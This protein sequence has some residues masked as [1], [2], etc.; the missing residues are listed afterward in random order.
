MPTLTLTPTECQILDACLHPADGEDSQPYRWLLRELGRAV[1]DNQPAAL[2]LTTEDLWFIR[3][4]LDPHEQVGLT[5]GADIIRRVYTTLLGVTLPDQG[6]QW[7]PAEN[8]SLVEVE[9]CRVQ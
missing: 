6:I 2:N 3:D 4:R 9:K 1:V 8:C 5:S 7:K